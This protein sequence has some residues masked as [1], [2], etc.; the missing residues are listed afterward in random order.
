MEKRPKKAEESKSWLKMSLLLFFFLM[1]LLYFELLTQFLIVI[2]SRRS[3]EGRMK[4]RTNTSKGIDSTGARPR[5]G[6]GGRGRQ[7]GAGLLSRNRFVGRKQES[8]TEQSAS[9]K[10]KNKNK[11][12]E[13][14]KSTYF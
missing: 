4:S 3:R 5:I 14:A 11:T 1:H 7:D 2:I 10:L 6:Q 8:Q 9:R 12:K 13:T